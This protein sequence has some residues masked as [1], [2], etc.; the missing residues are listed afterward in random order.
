MPA[1]AVMGSAA[2]WCL[3]RGCKADHALRRRIGSDESL[4]RAATN[5]ARAVR[6]PG[7]AEPVVIPAG[8]SG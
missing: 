8:A 3:D 6:S 4:M 1:H 5:G 2:L 7:I